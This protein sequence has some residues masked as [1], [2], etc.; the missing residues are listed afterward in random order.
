MATNVA[1][2]RPIL[3]CCKCI[4]VIYVSSPNVISPNAKSLN[5]ISPYAKSHNVRSP[6]LISPTVV[7]SPNVKPPNL[8]PLACHFM[9][10]GLLD[11]R[12]NCQH[13]VSR[14]FCTALIPCKN[15][16][17]T[18]WF[19]I[20]I[21]HINIRKIYHTLHL[22]TDWTSIQSERPNSLGLS[23]SHSTIITGFIPHWGPI[24]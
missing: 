3:L 9:C 18:T 23:Q 4:G 16:T 20:D 6:N 21:A 7:I 1:K 12:Q 22:L 10:L 17:R 24:P 14:G 13:E 11:L 2:C 19:Y 15:S 5:A 8:R